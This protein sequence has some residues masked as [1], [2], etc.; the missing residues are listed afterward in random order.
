MGLRRP[1]GRRPA[2]DRRHGR[3]DRAH[4]HPAPALPPGDRV[5]RRLR[6]AGL[7]GAGFDPGPR[8]A[9]WAA[10]ATVD[11]LGVWLAHP[12][13]GN[14]LDSRK[15]VF[16]AEHMVERI[17]LFIILQLGETVLALGGTISAAPVDVPTM[18]RT[19]RSVTVRTHGPH[20]SPATATVQ[21][22]TSHPP[23]DVERAPNHHR[24]SAPRGRRPGRLQPHAHHHYRK[25]LGPAHRSA[26]A[27]GAD[28]RADI[29][30][31]RERPA[32]QPP[33]ESDG[34]VGE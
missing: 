7:V 6:P 20:H 1:A 18:C 34:P 19:N 8:L 9:W 16:D 29:R 11:M 23:R 33:I 14:V 25:L 17:R 2:P 4:G 26:P 30:G 27:R 31:R 15:L 32:P 22:T 13:P 3:R 28:R 12:L 24:S 10:A 21:Q 5:D